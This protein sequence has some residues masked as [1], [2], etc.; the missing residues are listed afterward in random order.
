MDL[1]RIILQKTEEHDIS[2]GKPDVYFPDR[3]DNEISYHV[4]LLQE[5]GL[6]EAGIP[7]EIGGRWEVRRLTWAGHEFMDAIRNDTVWKTVNDEVKKQGVSIPFEI[8]KNLA[9]RACANLVG[10]T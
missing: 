5:A 6:I 1:C 10:L 4:R 9:L 3:P 2:T 7:C 8:L